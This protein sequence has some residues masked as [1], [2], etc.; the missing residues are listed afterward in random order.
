MSNKKLNLATN[1]PEK[2]QSRLMAVF[3]KEYKHEGLI[4][5]VLALIAIVLGVMLLVDILT[6]PSDVF[7][8]GDY[9]KPF[10]WTLLGLGVI[11]LIL[12]VWPFY[13]PS[14]EEIKRVSWPTKGTMISNSLTVFLFTLILAVFFALIDSGFSALVSWLDKIAG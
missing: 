2:K 11:S 12:A 4:L 9:P 8:L 7:L 6:I 5:F 14:I 10:A 13:K 3:A 1:K